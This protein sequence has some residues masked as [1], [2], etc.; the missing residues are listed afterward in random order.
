MTRVNTRNTLRL[1][2]PPNASQTHTREIRCASPFKLKAR[3]YFLFK[4]D[5][6]VE[7]TTVN[8]LRFWYWRYRKSDSVCF[9]F[10]F[11][12]FSFFSFFLSSFFFLFYFFNVVGSCMVL[13]LIAVRLHRVGRK[14]KEA[15]ENTWQ[16]FNVTWNNMNL[17][18]IRYSKRDR[19]LYLTLLKQRGTFSAVSVLP[20][21]LSN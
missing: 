11:Y 5:L 6:P 9:V 21:L 4:L 14:K 17:V 8:W 7:W 16:Y 12:S 15:K 20:S 2:F 1:Q 3:W 19:V 18:Q 10:F 13:V